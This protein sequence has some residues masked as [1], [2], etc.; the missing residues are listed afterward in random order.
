M[1]DD[2]KDQPKLCCISCCLLDG[3]GW[4]EEHEHLMVLSFDLIFDFCV[5]LFLVVPCVFTYNDPPK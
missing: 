1:I 2:R 4:R 3:G 5:I